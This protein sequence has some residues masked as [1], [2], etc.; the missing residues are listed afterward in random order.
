MGLI[1]L[2]TNLRSLSYGSGR[3]EPYVVQPL[4]AYDED[5]GNPYLGADM[6][7]RQ[8]QLQSNLTDVTRLTR[9]LTNGKGLLF[10]AKQIALEKT[11]PKVP[12]GP[13]RSFLFSTVL[14]QAGVQGTGIHFDRTNSLRVDNTEKY[15]YQT[16]TLYNDND[17]NR[18]TLLYSTK[19]AWDKTSTDKFDITGQNDQTTL[20][21]YGGGPGSVG[22]IGFTTIKRT[23]KTTTAQYDKNVIAL[24]QNNISELYKRST[25]TGFTSFS[26]GGGITN[27]TLALNG[28][29]IASPELKRKRLGRITRYDQFNRN[30][31]FKTGDPGNDANLNRQDYYSGKPKLTEGTD[32]INYKKVYSSTAGAQYGEGDASVEDMVKFYI[33]VIDNNN[34]QNKTYIHFR[35]YL[36]NLQDSYTAN[37]NSINYPGRGEEFFKYGGFSRDIGFDFK[38]HVASRIEL[39]PTYQKLNYLASVMAP[40]YS[41]TVGYM[42]GNIVQLTVGDYLNDVYG[43]ITNFSYNISEESTWDIARNNDGSIDPN[44]AELPMLID[45]NGFSFKPIHNFVPST[46]INPA[47]P[48]SKFI[49]MGSDAKGYK[50]ESAPPPTQPLPP[51]PIPT[52]N[53]LP[54]LQT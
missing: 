44:S 43:V 49:S 4:P 35:A 9:Y 39:F 2:K 28:K 23:T 10:N 11:R 54:T 6:F 21:Q 22:G 45:V 7:G 51:N 3:G 26:D 14:A 15:D 31:A 5:P 29:S 16:R 27:F 53:T 47:N 37:W 8:G 48:Q 12:Y 19:I 24:T 1:D 40:D 25:S 36:S 13:K 52:N 32:R 42:R 33:A 50:P 18:L 30:K 41:P 46:A 34:P 17:S 20:I 38:V